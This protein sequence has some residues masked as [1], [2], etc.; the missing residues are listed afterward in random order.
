MIPQRQTRYRS[1][2]HAETAAGNLKV[3][4]ARQL[5]PGLV[6]APQCCHQ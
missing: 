2:G 6:V 3:L 4:R 5:M 1:E